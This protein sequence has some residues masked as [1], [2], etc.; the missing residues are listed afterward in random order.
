VRLICNFCGAENAT[1]ME[2]PSAIPGWEFASNVSVVQPWGH[3]YTGN[4]CPKCLPDQLRKALVHAE[5]VS[6]GEHEQDAACLSCEK[7]IG[8]LLKHECMENSNPCP[9]ADLDCDACPYHEHTAE[10]W[11]SWVGYDAPTTKQGGQR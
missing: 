6:A 2:I 4:V 5:E 8:E 9:V 11:Y 3:P 1:R 7:L 10:A